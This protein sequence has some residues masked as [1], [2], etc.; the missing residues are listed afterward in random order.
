M[1]FMFLKVKR[2]FFYKA[3]FKHPLPSHRLVFFK[4]NKFLEA[5][6]KT[7]FYKISMDRNRGLRSHA[8]VFHM[9]VFL[10]FANQN[11]NGL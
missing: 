8:S 5:I 2:Q 11:Q 10:F 7:S 6:A 3:I 9:S 1:S 4:K